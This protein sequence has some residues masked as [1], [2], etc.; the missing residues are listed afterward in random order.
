M[1]E[2]FESTI[3]RLLRDTSTPAVV[4][5][6]ESGAWPAALWEAVDA[7]GFALAAAPESAGGAG[8]TWDDLFVVLAACGRHNAPVPLPEAMLANWLLGRAGLDAVSGPLSCAAHSTLAVSGGLVSGRLA[9]VPW[10]RHVAHVVALANDNGAPVIVLLNTAHSTQRALRQNVAGEPRDDLD[11][12]RSTPLGMA[13]LPVGLAPDVLLQG[14]ALLRAAQTAGALQALLEMSTRHATERVQFGKAIGSF[15][16]IGHQIAVLAEHVALASVTAEAACAES[17]ETSLALLPIAAAKVCSAEAAS[18][19]AGI[20]HAVHGAIGFT[21]EHRL[22]LTTRRLWAWRS[23]YGSLTDW[24]Q[25]IGRAAC[26]GGAADFWP[27]VTRGSWP[28]L[29]QGAPA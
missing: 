18:V 26:A 29:T 15:Q 5:A 23:E 19:A 13:A 8:A 6:C 24:S 12:D 22:H 7:S 2:I 9:D 21:H 16:A 27:T 10:G 14:G 4:L 25:R 20:A 17:T 28:G 11:F 1:R 3:E